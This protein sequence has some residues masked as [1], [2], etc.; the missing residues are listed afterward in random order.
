[1][2]SRQCQ[3]LIRVFVSPLPFSWSKYDDDANEENVRETFLFDVY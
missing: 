1:M 3:T 2:L